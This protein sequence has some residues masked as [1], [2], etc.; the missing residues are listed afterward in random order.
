M[1]PD[2]S[3]SP[4][5][6][7][8][9]LRWLYVDFNSYFASVEQ[10]LSPE[11]RGRPVIVVPVMT[12]STCAIAASYEAK[13]FGIKTGTPVYE[14]RQKCPGLACVPARHEHYVE[15]HHRLIEE[16][17]RHVPVTDVCS[18]D[19]M[20]CRL[21]RNEAAPATAAGIAQSIKDGIAR[22]IGVQLRCS[23]GIAPNKYLAKIATD[24]QKPDGLVTLHP[25][26]LPRRLT[27]L[28]L[29]DLPGV[30]ANVERRLH[31]AGI[32][33]MKTLLELQPRHLRAVWGN[34]WGEK[35]W[36]LLRGFDLPD[37]ETSRS[38][39]GH[40]HVLAPDLRPPEV[41]RHVARRLLMKAAA[42]LRRMEYDA[43]ALVLAVRI[44]NGPR[45]GVEGRC[46]PTQDSPGL[47]GLLDALWQA[48]T[49]E[50]TGCRLR[51]VS[52]TLHGL[53]PQ[54]ERGRQGDLFTAD[55]RSLSQRRQNRNDKIS[56]AMDDLN[57]K[58]GRDTVLMGMP[59]SASR[60]FSGTKVAFTRIP[61]V[62][63]FLE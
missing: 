1:F 37:G 16:I 19:E 42:R 38:T 26:D 48:L 44:E 25:G 46:A 15:F 60:A 61:D 57:R 7:P 49:P 55:S 47:L 4:L 24:M 11:L 41:A 31:R 27:G 12:D 52:V 30:G 13:A 50:M 18:I 9:A 20:A 34:I 17:G 53:T 22:H 63:E 54:S 23:I 3:D 59:A 21:M 43:A 28:A 33:D 39:I 2:D 32:F 8:D 45:F 10:Q 29:R 58:F 5:S 56:Q 36:Y 62:D 40:S 51:K 14:A 35:L 6:P